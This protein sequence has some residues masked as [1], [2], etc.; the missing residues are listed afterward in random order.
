[1]TATVS[2][3]L[4]PDLGELS[5]GIDIHHF[6]ADL[7]LLLTVSSLMSPKDTLVFSLFSIFK[8]CTDDF[9]AL[10]V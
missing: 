9:P 10:H 4:L 3:S 1:M 8:D 6:S 7:S 2:S 5:P